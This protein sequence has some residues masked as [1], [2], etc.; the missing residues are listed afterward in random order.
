MSIK[1]KKILASDDFFTEKVRLEAEFIDFEKKILE[2]NE[3]LVNIEESLQKMLALSEENQTVYFLQR[4][5]KLHVA[6][7]TLRHHKGYNKE[8]FDPIYHVLNK[9]VNEDKI[10]FLDSALKNRIAK[11][12][13]TLSVSEDKP[14]RSKQEDLS[15]KDVF[16]S[17]VLEGTHFLVPKLPHRILKNI[18]AFKSKMMIKK[19]VVPLFPGPGFVLSEDSPKENKKK[20]LVLKL[21]ST[22]EEG[23]YFDRLEEDWA[24]SKESILSLLK[25]EK[26]N[27]KIMGKIRR[28]GI[29]YHLIRV[30][31]K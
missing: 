31:G 9:I 8:D 12:A 4:V 1:S 26:T 22:R 11:V 16:T 17:F 5:K 13:R 30:G 7:H 18:P 24:I 23:F 21:D 29:H 6:F 3:H 20:V 15:G 25:E 27:G 10:E 19:K 2:A 14:S 28:K